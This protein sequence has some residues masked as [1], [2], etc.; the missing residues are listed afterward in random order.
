ML[1]GGWLQ[2]PDLSFWIRSETEKK[3]F[4][5]FFPVFILHTTAFLRV[6]GTARFESETLVQFDPQPNL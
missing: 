4:F 6:F 3:A 2:P 5:F 1:G